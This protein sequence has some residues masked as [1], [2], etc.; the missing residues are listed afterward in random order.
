MKKIVRTLALMLVLSMAATGCQ[1]ENL[2]EPQG[3][4]AENQTV[5]KVVYTV[6]GVSGSATLTGEAEWLA[7]MNRMVALA[8]EGRSVTF[9]NEGKVQTCNAK[10]IV[11]Y[12]TSSKP[13][14][15]AWAAAMTD[16]GYYVTITYN[17]R[18]QMYECVAIK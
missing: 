14:A 11:T 16:N 15:I 3:V 10:E 7:F 13:D 4:V 12:T 2:L 1:K 6:D 17:E 5:R 18:T 8:E 9:W